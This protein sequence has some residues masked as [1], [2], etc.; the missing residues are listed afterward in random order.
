MEHIAIIGGGGTAAALAHD[1]ILRGFSVALYERGEFFSG[2]TGRHHGLLHSGA[3]YAVHDP[4]AAREC[5]EENMILRRL[6]PQ[7]MEQNEGL[8]VA[9]DDEDMAYRQRL[10]EA[11]AATGIPTRDYTPEQAHRLEPGLADSILAAMQVPDATFDAWRLALPF[12]ATARAGGATAHNFTEVVGIDVQGGAVRGLRLRTLTED[13]HGTRGR[14]WSAP[15]DLVVNAAGAW[16]GKVA[17]LAGVHVPI[18]PGP[19]VLVAI[20]GRVTNMVIN[21]MRKA[22]EG[23]IIVPQRRLSVLG[24]SMWLT[25]DPDHLDIPPEH[26]ERMVRLCSE[27]VPACAGASIRSAWS[28]ARPLIGN[29]DAARPQEISRTFDCYDHGT[30]D[31]VSG[32]LSIIGGKG[33]TLRAMA[34]K[35]ADIICRLTGHDAPCRTRE[36][37]LLP[38]RTFY[39]S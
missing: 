11:C 31:N 10:K 22:S 1:L 2:S 35:T 34:E 27:M 5:I 7:A 8:F 26:V 23:D 37:P 9:L 36:T 39:R 29:A 3:R 6:V 21:R 25:D 17:A 4:E 24:T 19:G 18:Q 14:E 30:R 13:A 32:L 12:L 15:A 16:A 20:E 33:M 28:A 38:A